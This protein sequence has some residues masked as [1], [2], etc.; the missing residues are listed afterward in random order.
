[1]KKKQHKTNINY[2]QYLLTILSGHV[3]VSLYESIDTPPALLSIWLF[4]FR[5]C[6]DLNLSSLTMNPCGS[7]ALNVRLHGPICK[8]FGSKS[9]IMLDSRPSTLN[10]CGDASCWHRDWCVCADL[11]IG[12]M[13]IDVEPP[14]DVTAESRAIS[15]K[16]NNNNC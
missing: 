1:M 8:R 13:V 15:E 16:W 4:G 5:I 3:V 14:V 11:K 12:A 2:K 7:G 9:S 6:F 10:K